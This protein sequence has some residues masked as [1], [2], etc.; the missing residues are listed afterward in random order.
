[1][2][3]GLDLIPDGDETGRYRLPRSILHLRRAQIYT[4]LDRLDLAVAEYRLVL[5][6]DPDYAEYHL[7]LGNMLRTLGRDDE[8][9]AEYDR[10]IALSPR[11]PRRTTTGRTSLPPAA[12]WSLRWPASVTLWSSRPRTWTRTST[13]PPS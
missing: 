12:T 7:E 11:S 5:E 8:A 13:R 1:M 3:E 9:L 6:D 10:A 2:S 4:G